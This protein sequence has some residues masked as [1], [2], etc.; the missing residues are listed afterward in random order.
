MLGFVRSARKYE[1]FVSNNGLAKELLQRFP[2]VAWGM[3]YRS[4]GNKLGDLDKG[5]INWWAKNPEKAK[6][7]AELLEVSLED[8]GLHGKIQKGVFGFQEFPEFPP[9]ELK[10]EEPWVLMEA[11]LDPNQVLPK[12]D[13]KDSLEHWFGREVLGSWRPPYQMD[14]LCISDELHRQ[15]LSKILGANSRHEVVYAETVAEVATRLANPKPL[16]VSVIHDGGNEDLLA[17]AGRPEDAGLLVIAPFMLDVREETSSAEYLGWE[18]RTAGGLQARVFGLTAAKWSFRSEFKRWT[19]RKLPDWREQLLAWVETRLNRSGVDTFFNA[20]AVSDWLNRFDPLAAWFCTTSD[21]MQLCRLAHLDSEKRL[22]EPSDFNAGNRLVQLLFARESSSCVFRIKQLADA[23]W[24]RNDLPWEGSLSLDNWSA[25]SADGAASVSRSLLDQIVCGRTVGEREKAADHVAN[26]LEAGNPDALLSTG[27]VVER[28]RGLFDFQHPTF[29]GL[30]IRDRLMKQ[31]A[32]ESSGTW[33]MNCFDPGR[34]LLVDAA[35]EVVSM[36]CL[37]SAAQRLASEPEKSAQVIA[38]SEAL[39]VAIGKRI[40]NEDAISPS[41]YPIGKM[42]VQRLDLSDEWSLAEPWSRPAESDDDRLAWIGACWSWSLLPEAA[43]KVGQSWLFPGWAKELPETPY[44]LAALNP[45][46]KEERISP[47]FRRFLEVVHQWA[48]ELDTPI[49]NGP[50]MLLLPFM[51]K[52]ARGVLPAEGAWW[53]A[54]IGQK[55]AESLLLESFDLSGK[56]AAGR[57]WPS[58]LAVERE[59]EAERSAEDKYNFPHLMFHVSPV[60]VWLLR[61]LKPTEVLAGLSDV[62][63]T[64]LGC[65]PESLPPEVRSPLLLSLVDCSPVRSIFNALPFFERFGFHAAPA[66]EAYLEHEVL[67]GGAAQCLWRWSPE[68]AANLIVLGDSVSLEVRKTLFWQC[69]E[70]Y[71]SLAVEALSVASALFDAEER[72]R[73]VR[74]YLPSAGPYAVTALALLDIE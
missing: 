36:E 35:L 31:I 48:K 62:D 34:R 42:V 12:S 30:L 63:R 50:T 21:V 43:V 5:K 17:L 52:V 47:M 23:R 25:I 65:C 14:W 66:L 20:Q 56:D 55:W 40:A 2:G 37:V 6:C 71:F 61:H 70:Q 45:E 24:Q 4:L 11:V 73:W 27:L 18:S 16:I 19:L 67:G 32:A 7:L 72:K 13:S 38:A 59:L 57:L 46:N 69:P 60:R 74:K 41:L 53:K 49:E 8:L 64:Y 39:F 26:L 3:E 51:S 10:R 68:R 58:F 29:A 33:A 1:E 9:L 15:L 22:P 44:W 28:R 54:L